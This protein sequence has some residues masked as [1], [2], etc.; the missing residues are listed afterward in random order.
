MPNIPMNRVSFW[1][2]PDMSQSSHPSEPAVPG[3]MLPPVEPPSAGFIL[4][5]FVVPG[6]IVVIIVMVW[7]LFNWV[8]RTGN[9]PEEYVRALKRENVNSWQAAVNL[10]NALGN[11]N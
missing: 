3:D 5:L 9:D 10:A 8:A 11:P 1:R 4:Q 2:S 7:L 6:I